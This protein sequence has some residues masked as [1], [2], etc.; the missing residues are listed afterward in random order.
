MAGM[1]MGKSGWTEIEHTAD[2][3]LHVWAPDLTELLVQAAVGMY[4][5]S[6]TRLADSPRISRECVIPYQDRES[7]MVDF[8]SE[9]LFYAEDAAVGFDTI[10]PTLN[11]TSCV[12]QLDGAA[13]IQQDKE[14]KAVTFHGLKVIE[15]GDQLEVNIVFD[16]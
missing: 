15:S 2:W 1:M 3:E 11:E 12:F 13:I 4:A 7:L 10:R 8:L 5:L 6:G 9:L 16:V 14:I